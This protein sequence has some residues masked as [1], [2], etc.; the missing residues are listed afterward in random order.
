MGY[1][2]VGRFEG[3]FSFRF[4][5]SEEGLKESAIENLLNHEGSLSAT[6]TYFIDQLASSSAQESGPTVPSGFR[7]LLL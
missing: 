2:A 1:P 4:H 3:G 7:F 5:L 6:E